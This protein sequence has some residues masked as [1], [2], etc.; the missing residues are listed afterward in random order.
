MSED[1]E[2]FYRV[3]VSS[4]YRDL[5]DE[6]KRIS[7][8]LLGQSCFPAGMEYFP[9]SDGDIWNIIT[10]TIDT[11][12]YYLLIIGARYGEIATEGQSYT[13][14]EYRYAINQNIP[15]IVCVS[16][17]A[18]SLLK[19]YD[20]EAD[21]KEKLDKFV[22]FAESKAKYKA[23]WEDITDLAVR[24]TESIGK[25]IKSNPARGWVREE[26]ETAPPSL[27][28]DKLHKDNGIIASDDSNLPESIGLSN[29]SVGEL[30]V[31]RRFKEAPE[32]RIW[33]KKKRTFEIPQF[34]RLRSK[35]IL[36]L[37]FL[38]A[39]ESYALLMAQDVQGRFINSI[40]TSLAFF[41]IKKYPFFVP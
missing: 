27:S 41:S 26:S 32:S 16:G 15:R 2:K 10:Q 7:S 24:I 20:L 18:E 5:K 12:D 30:Y 3:F 8:V 17:N 39:K 23:Y 37:I 36:L 9:S 1:I 11:C 21:D 31:C 6:R 13:E 34:K 4:T 22:T 14:K 38:W 40:I 25:I 28:V 19:K 33:N 29:L 35:K